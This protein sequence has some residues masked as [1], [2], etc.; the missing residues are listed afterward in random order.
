M[1]RSLFGAVFPHLWHRALGIE[2]VRVNLYIACLINFD[3]YIINTH[4]SHLMWFSSRFSFGIAIKRR[5]RFSTPY[6][7]IVIASQTQWNAKGNR[8]ILKRHFQFPVL[9]Y[10]ILDL[11]IKRRMMNSFVVRIEICW[12]RGSYSR[13]NCRLSA[14]LCCSEKANF[15]D[16]FQS[17]WFRIYQMIWTNTKQQQTTASTK[18]KLV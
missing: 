18:A 4:C 8:S 10:E 13:D 15:I 3:N 16:Y 14:S 2:L 9:F 11:S 7:K 5:F 1:S 6:I 12:Q 17:S